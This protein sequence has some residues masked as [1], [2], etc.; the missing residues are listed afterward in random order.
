MKDALLQLGKERPNVGLARQPNHDL[1]LLNLDV[2]RVVVL[3][4][5]YSHLVREKVGVRLEQERDVSEGDPLNFGR[6]RDEG[7]CEATSKP[8]QASFQQKFL[9][10]EDDKGWKGRTDR[11]E[12]PFS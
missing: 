9:A 11:E 5:E 3:A 6:G 12:E 4:E 8:K 7:D 10:S 2:R 1:E